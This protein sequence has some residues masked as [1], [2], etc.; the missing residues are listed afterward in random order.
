MD[1]EVIWTRI[2]Y[3]QIATGPQRKQDF[4]PSLNCADDNEKKEEVDLHV[5]VYAMLG[6]DVWAHIKE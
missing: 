3:E 6:K 1:I 2:V 4:G 5:E